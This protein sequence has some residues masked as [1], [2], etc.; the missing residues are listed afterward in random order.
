MQNIETLTR[1]LAAALQLTPAYAR[2]VAAKEENEADDEL[3]AQMRQ[4]EL[5]RL[6]YQ[7]EAQKDENADEALMEGYDAQFT[8]QYDEIMENPHMQE[9]QTAA[10]AIDALLKRVTGI[11]AGAAQ[12]EDPAA[13]EPEAGCGGSCGG[14]HGCG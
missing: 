11:L 5:L 4:L 8:A 10:Q 7:H 13:Y 6:Q 9:Y 3:N 14:C 1:E 12:G 2:Y